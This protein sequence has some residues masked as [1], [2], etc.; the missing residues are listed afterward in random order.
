MNSTQ[1]PGL[2]SA[3]VRER[4]LGDV[5]RGPVTFAAGQR[6]G[7][8]EG[9]PAAVVL[10]CSDLRELPERVL[11][12]AIGPIYAVQT[13]GA[14]VTPTVSASLRYALETTGARLLLVLGHTRCRL[15]E[16]CW[17]HGATP[18]VLEGLLAPGFEKARSR[19]DTGLPAALD[20]TNVHNAH[21]ARS[22]VA[23][24]E[25][26]LGHSVA[27]VQ[28]LYDE[29]QQKVTLSRV[30]EVVQVGRED[31]PAGHGVD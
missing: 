18:A 30:G 25:A 8:V 15:V 23:M 31:P 12:E 13:A 4:L 26:A 24:W 16:H 6:L 21:A 14:L 11:G 3:V 5:L 29:D 17:G 20:S 28:G 7:P 27:V 10:C 2:P 19:P 1:S 9:A 22:L